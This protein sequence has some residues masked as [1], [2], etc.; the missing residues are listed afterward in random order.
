MST[1]ERMAVCCYCLP[2]VGSSKSHST[3]FGALC[4]SCDG[5]SRGMKVS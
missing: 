4:T 1:R 5:V 2:G 3:V